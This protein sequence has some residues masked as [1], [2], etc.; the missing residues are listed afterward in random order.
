MRAFID[1]MWAQLREYFG[2]MSRGSR[3]RLAILSVLV[4]ALAIVAVSLFTQTT[5]ALLH[6]A[7]DQA[8]VG[9]IQ[10]ALR[11]M[12]VPFETD[13][14]RIRVPEKRVQEVKGDLAAQGLLGAGLPDN[15]IGAGASGFAVTEAHAR[16]LYAAQDAEYI[17][18]AILTSPR[19]SSAH[20]VVKPGETSP[21]RIQTGV[22]SATTSVMVTVVG[23]GMLSPQEAQAIAEY[24]RGVVPGI[25]YENINITDS[26]L[27]H[28]KVGEL[29]MDFG[30]EM[31]TRV[32]L[33]MMLQGQMQ[34]QI[35]QIIAPIFGMNNIEVTTRIELFWDKQ[36]TESVVFNPPVA[37]ELDGI[38]R[39][40][41][42]LWEAS[43]KAESAATGVPGTDSNAMGTVEYPYGTLED[44]ELYQ[45]RLSDR[46]YEINETREIIEKA[47]G[48]VEFIS[49]AVTINEEAV[50]EDYTEQVR[51]LITRGLGILQANVSV[52]RMPF[53]YPDTSL[54]DAQKALA[55]Q[56]A[57]NRRQELIRTIIMWAVLLLLG[58]MLML[59]IWTIVRAVKPPPEPEPVLVGA[60]IDYIADEEDYEEIEEEEY[61]EVELQ[62]KPT[63]LEQIERF[64]D[65]DPAAVAQLLRNWLSDE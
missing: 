16:W 23:G 41:S 64:I 36:V 62:K 8:E 50:E 3:I 61:E 5:Y 19:I 38:A 12:G 57:M 32:A 44:G 52:E 29:T 35:E 49:V 24:V 2:N 58:L 53:G 4:I 34:S 18:K 33:R 9:N 65:K 27:N 26:N 22:R 56:E 25:E 21:F 30:T 37:G 10:A 7:Q 47:Q 31:E 39:S 6:T 46:N 11:D 55:E 13:G 28:Y 20:V 17:R 48:T 60:G 59:L 15:T 14:L 63:G 51:N 40:S 42:D 1:R 43:R 45:K 54:E